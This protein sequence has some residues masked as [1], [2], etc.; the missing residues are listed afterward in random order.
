MVEL[1]TS[2]EQEYEHLISHF[3]R[4]IRL[5]TIILTIVVTLVVGAGSLFFYK[6]VGDMKAD[7]KTAVEEVKSS[8]QRDIAKAKDE[9]L[10]TVRAEAKKRVDEEFNSREITE[11]VE[12]AAKHKVGRTIDRQI[13]EE[14]AVSVGRVQDQIIETTE[15]ENLVIEI[16]LLGFRDAFDELT[17]RYKQSDDPGIRRTEKIVLDSVITDYDKV[18]VST[19]RRDGRTAQ[20]QLSAWVPRPVDQPIPVSTANFVR[21]IRIDKDL[22]RVGLA[23][24]A[25]RDS[26]GV[27]F[28]MLDFDAI[29]KWCS[30]NSKQ[31]Q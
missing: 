9:V 28:P 1:P 20:Q 31:C 25:L 26:T 3:E 29:E 2:S 14:V 21:V 27:H 30:E 16:R 17:K 4:L 5:T 19:L 22:N 7:A 6:S 11:L 13:Q 10:D 23:F 15:I 8:A 12:A 18:L 24:L